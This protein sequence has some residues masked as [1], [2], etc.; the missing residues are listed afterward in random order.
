MNRKY[1]KKV[2]I[3]DALKNNIC[4]GGIMLEPRLQEFV[5][6]K[7]YYKENK[8][9]PCIK[10]EKEFQISKQDIKTL[11]RFFKGDKDLYSLRYNE[12]VLASKH[13]GIVKE[14]KDKYYDQRSKR[15]KRRKQYF[16]SKAFRDNDPRVPVPLKDKPNR[17][18]NMGMFVPD[19]GETYFEGNVNVD[20]PRMDMRDMSGLDLSNSGFDLNDT[21]FDPRN[22]PYIYPGTEEFSKYGSQFRVNPKKQS[23]YRNKEFNP[24]H[25]NKRVRSD[26]KC[27]SNKNIPTNKSLNDRFHEKSFAKHLRCGVASPTDRNGCFADRRN[28]YI[29]SDL[30]SSNKQKFNEFNLNN[31][32][33]GNSNFASFSKNNFEDNKL[34]EN[35]DKAFKSD[36]RYA[37]YSEPVFSEKSTMDTEL[38]V[39]IPKMSSK[40]NDLNSSTYIPNIHLDQ[41]KNNLVDDW[42]SELESTMILGMP[43]R[44]RKSY[45][46]RNPFENYFQYVEE[47]FVNPDNTQ[48]PWPR[49]G[50]A[51]RNFNKTEA[52]QIHTR[53]FSQT[54]M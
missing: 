39:V 19:E 15:S 23:H 21:R 29:I 51:T 7:M 9:D 37:N 54:K 40:S 43:T 4:T 22:D 38:K 49:G 36:S 14:R 42:N 6:K 41:H 28:N 26:I 48:L 45:G 13:R 35:F 16:P 17:P 3:V 44:T 25:K 53:D 5:K 24:L 33:G 46:Y 27:P 2:D 8:I 50:A 52:R 32:G 12:K 47:D 30:G 10:P 11:K 1:N 34:I 20:N 18:V 31:L